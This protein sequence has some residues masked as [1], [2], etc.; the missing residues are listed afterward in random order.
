MSRFDLGA[1][2]R[3]V[4]QERQRRRLTWAGLANEVGVAASTI[5]RYRQADDAEADGVLTLVHWLGVAPENYMTGGP[6]RGVLLRAGSDRCVRVDMELV[7]SACG[8]PRGS[9]GRSRTTIQRLVE[10]ADSSGQPV[11]SL[12]RQVPDGH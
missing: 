11:A 4:D 10:V 1:L 2:Y 5:R 6:V 7:A 9:V 8:D 12:T 3:S